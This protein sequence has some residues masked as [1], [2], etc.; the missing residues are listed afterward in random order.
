MIQKLLCWLYPIF[1]SKWLTDTSGENS[2]VIKVR[3]W[4]TAL[5]ET[6]WGT[7]MTITIC[8]WWFK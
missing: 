7:R 1:Y 2:K 3:G 5:I 6:R 8:F 4:R